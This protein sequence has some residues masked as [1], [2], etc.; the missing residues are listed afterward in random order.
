MEAQPGTA[1]K[2]ASLTKIGA[3]PT[4]NESAE[5]GKPISQGEPERGRENDTMP[6]VAKRSILLSEDFVVPARRAARE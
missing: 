3:T 2:P 6:S 4:R 5:T 1:N